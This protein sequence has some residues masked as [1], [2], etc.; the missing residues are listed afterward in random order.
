MDRRELLTVVGAAVALGTAS[1][2]VA[3]GTGASSMHPPR[4]KALQEA[5]AH[6]VATAND[7]MRHCMGMLAMKDTSMSGCMDAAYQV[8]VACGALQALAAVNSPQVPAI[9][10][11]VGAIC[12]ACKTE[13]DKFP[14][15]A[16][17][18]ACGAACQTCADECRKASA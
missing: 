1:Q 11:A 13:C 5:T 9:A 8:V 16:E 6:C 18:K 3:Q 2:A 12:T 14:A 4:Y 17:C 10:K 7:C 15:V